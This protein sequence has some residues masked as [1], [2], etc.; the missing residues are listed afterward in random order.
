MGAFLQFLCRTDEH[1]TWALKVARALAETWGK[2]AAAQHVRQL[3]HAMEL[4]ATGSARSSR[5]Q[6]RLIPRRPPSSAFGMVPKTRIPPGVAKFDTTN[7]RSETVGEK[8]SFSGPWKKGQLCLV[9]AASFYEPFYAEGQAKSVRWRIWL[10]G[11]LEFA[12]ASLWRDWPDGAFSFTMLTINSDKHPLM[13]RFHAPGKE[14]RMIVIVPLA[15]WD[16]WLTCRD[17][18]RA[19][20]FMRPYPPEL[21]DAEAAP[22]HATPRR[23]RIEE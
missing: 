1:E 23:G 13:N 2:L 7:A 12:I 18:E 14:K 17:P 5:V 6:S 4:V 8:R 10:K 3:G 16:D 15:E 19:R 21:I 11:E 20:S 22:R 9:P